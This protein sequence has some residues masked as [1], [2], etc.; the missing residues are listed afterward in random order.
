MKNLRKA[1]LAMAACALTLAAGL[2]GCQPAESANSLVVG[3]V[4]TAELLHD[5]PQYQSLS[6]EYMKENT[7][8][9]GKFVEKMRAAGEDQE[10]KGKVQGAY[11]GE[12]QK[13]DAK[14]MGKTQEF[15]E[16]RHS[17]IRDTAQTVAEHKNIDIVIIDSQVYPTTEWGGVDITKDLALSLSQGGGAPAASPSPGKKEG[18]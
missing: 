12:Q 3:K 14:W 13:L 6:I 4:D 1:K 8:L 7:D 11:K 2:S 15:L 16:S 5:D 9:R 17:S 18:T 10:A